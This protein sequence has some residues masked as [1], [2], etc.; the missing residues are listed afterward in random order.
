MA[1]N[2]LLTDQCGYRYSLIEHIHTWILLYTPRLRSV[3]K[4]DRT[5]IPKIDL[6]LGAQHSQPE[7]L[8]KATS[9]SKASCR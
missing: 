4:H 2:L 8:L 6:Y 1:R 3:P 5:Q 9:L 7:S